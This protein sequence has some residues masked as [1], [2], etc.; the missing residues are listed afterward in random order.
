[1]GALEAFR[2][3]W[4]GLAANKFRSFLTMLGVIIGV[5]AVI[6]MVALGEGAA[7]ATQ[8]ELKKMGTNRLYVRPEEQTSRGVSQGMGSGQLLTLEHAEALRRS[9]RHLVAVVPEFRW[10]GDGTV[11]YGNKNT[12]TRVT[13]TTPEYFMVRNLPIALGRSFT[14][15][16]VER[17]ARV[18]VIGHTVGETLFG[19]SQALGKQILIGAQRF[20]VVGIGKRMGDMPFGNPDDQV[21]VPITTAMRRLGRSIYLHSLSVQAGSREHLV[22]A[23]EEIN[24]FFARALRRHMNP[25]DERPPIRVFNQADVLQTADEQSGFL[26]SLLAGLAAVSLVVGGI[27]IMN[28]MLVSVTERTREIGI[29]K[30]LGARRRDILYQFLIE[31]VALSVAGGVIGILAGVAVSVW[32]G[33]PANRGGAGFPMA[34]TAWPVVTSFWFSVLVG[35]FFG[36]YPAF[37]ASLLDPIQALRCE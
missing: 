12:R 11:E 26:S 34:L 1:M 10:R 13:G 8:A 6:V 15:E 16:E 25:E 7:R 35:I 22:D 31:S 19:G 21:T 36:I 18:C 9:T 30:A 5:A 23:E 3:A 14:A 24:A 28:I 20:E 29:R 32:M 33:T 37:K 2:V 17:K 4:L 27:G